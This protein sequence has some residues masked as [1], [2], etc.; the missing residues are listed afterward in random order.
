MIYF[1]WVPPNGAIS[2]GWIFQGA[3]IT[4]LRMTCISSAIV[5]PGLGQIGLK[6]FVLIPIEVSWMY[7]SMYTRTCLFLLIMH[8]FFTLLFFLSTLSHKRIL[9][10]VFLKSCSSSTA[11]I[12]WWSIWFSPFS[13]LCPYRTLRCQENAQCRAFKQRRPK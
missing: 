12:R 6:T 4:L 13:L 10:I 11:T 8:I 5:T 9:L 7:N 3:A 1:L 2:C